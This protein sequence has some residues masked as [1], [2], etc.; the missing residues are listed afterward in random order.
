MD[1]LRSR[2]EKL[3]YFRKLIIG[4]RKRIEISIK[5]G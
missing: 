3:D 5:E 2:A 4:G 1:G